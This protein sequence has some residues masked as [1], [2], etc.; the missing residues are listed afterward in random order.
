ME[1][2]SA[3]LIIEF[4]DFH[5]NAPLLLPQGVAMISTAVKKSFN[6]LKFQRE[7]EL[8]D[9]ASKSSIPIRHLNIGF[10]GKEIDVRFYMDNQ[11]AT[12]FLPHF[13]CF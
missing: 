7:I 10:D 5:Q 1:F 12:L 2:Y 11:F 4:I 13:R 8:P 9:F 3:L 6:K